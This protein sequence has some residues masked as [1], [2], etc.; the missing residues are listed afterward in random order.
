[1]L[2]QFHRKRK[3]AI[4][5]SCV[6]TFQDISQVRSK[7]E[8]ESKLGEKLLEFLVSC[9]IILNNSLHLCCLMGNM[10]IGLCGN[11]NAHVAK[12]GPLQNDKLALRIYLMHF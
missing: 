2:C 8:S 6:T 7:K 11:K 3:C 10:F 1:M 9:E 4:I 5:L 12:C